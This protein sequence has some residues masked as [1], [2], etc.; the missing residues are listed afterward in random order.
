[1]SK[2]RKLDGINE[3]EQYWKR[4][5]ARQKEL[6]TSYKVV[7]FLDNYY[8]ICFTASFYDCEEEQRQIIEGTIELIIEKDKIVELK[9]SY[10]KKTV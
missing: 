6:T 2:N 4:N 5:K 9:E 10:T 1:M 3:I 8:N 7:V